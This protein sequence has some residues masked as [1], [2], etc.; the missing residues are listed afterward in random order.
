[1]N[2]CIG[3]L[4]VRGTMAAGDHLGRSVVIRHVEGREAGVDVWLHRGRRCIEVQRA[5]VALHVGNLPEAGDDARDAQVGRKVDPF[6]STQC[7]G[8]ASL[9]WQRR[10]SSAGDVDAATDAWRQRSRR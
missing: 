2:S 3:L 7:H 9:G 4:A 1:M 5:A 10:G 6:D 8:D